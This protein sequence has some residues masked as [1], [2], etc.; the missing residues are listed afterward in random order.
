MRSPGV[1]LYA[2]E[3]HAPCC[4]RPSR[5]LELGLDIFQVGLAVLVALLANAVRLAI[6]RV[7]FSE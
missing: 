6:E 7:V 1:P 4:W 2:K 3:R 5:E